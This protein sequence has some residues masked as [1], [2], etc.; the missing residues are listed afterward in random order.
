M[1]K[2]IV[3]IAIVVILALMAVSGYNNL[4]TMSENVNGKWSQIDNQLQRRADLI[5]NLVSTVKGYAAQEQQ[6]FTQVAEARSKLAG[7]GTPAQAAEANQEVSSALSRLLAIA[8]AYPQL[9]SDANFR[10]LS[11]ELAGTE[12]RIATARKDYNEAVQVYNA[13]IKRIPT[14]LYAGIFGFGPREYFQTS[15]EARQAPQVDFSK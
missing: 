2:W 6:I 15:E 3:P 14:V 1:R 7:A 4:V 5:P 13:R 8:E 11:D 10:Q 9:K 12:N